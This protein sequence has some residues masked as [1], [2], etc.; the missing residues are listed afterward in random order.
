MDRKKIIWSLIVGGLSGELLVMWLVPKYITWY[1]DPPVEMGFSCTEPIRWALNRL[2]LAQFIGLG[3]G[4]IGG[5]L[6]LFL[7]RSRSAPTVQG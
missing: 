5:L 3:V 7:L 6:V 4:A 2:V 1:F